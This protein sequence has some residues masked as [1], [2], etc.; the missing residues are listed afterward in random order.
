MLTWH[1]KCVHDCPEGYRID[2]VECIAKV[3]QLGL[4]HADMAPFTS[5]PCHVELIVME[6]KETIKANP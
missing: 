1:N 6:K 3:N 2:G 5:N 4:P